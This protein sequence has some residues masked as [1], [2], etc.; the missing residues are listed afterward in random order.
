MAYA[1]E[2]ADRYADK[3]LAQPT[4]ELARMLSA[5]GNQADRAIGVAQ[6]LDRIADEIFGPVP[7]EVPRISD[8]PA[9]HALTAQIEEQIERLNNA[10]GEVEANLNR[11][12]RLVR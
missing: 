8:R 12:S 5:I 3:V 10:L 4:G 11:M 9:A 6:E 1:N 7:A 2:T